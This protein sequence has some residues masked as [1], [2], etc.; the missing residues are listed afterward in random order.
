[1]LPKIAADSAKS[2]RTIAQQA[3]KLIAQE[4]IEVFKSGAKQIAGI[5]SIPSQQPT[6][7]ASGQP[8]GLPREDLESLKQQD[9]AK[10]RGLMDKLEGDLKAIRDREQ[11]EKMQKEAMQQNLNATNAEPQNLVEPAPKRSRNILKGMG[12][13]L[14]DLKKRAEIR[15]PPSG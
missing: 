2:A 13:K 15:M 14:S 12:K 3:A 6:P 4:P 10:S 8:E 7:T 9:L 11:Q 1:M 5:E